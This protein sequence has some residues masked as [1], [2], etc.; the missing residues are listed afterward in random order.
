MKTHSIVAILGLSLV[1]SIAVA[2][3]IPDLSEIHASKCFRECSKEAKGDCKIN[4]DSSSSSSSGGGMTSEDDCFDGIENCFH[5]AADCS[6]YCLTCKEPGS[7]SLSQ[8]EC[9]NACV[10]MA[11]KCTDQIQPCLDQEKE[12]L[13]GDL[14]DVGDK[15]ADDCV[16][17][18][19]DCV[20]DCIADIEN[21]LRGKKD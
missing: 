11:E 13:K 1:G 15:L 9:N 7:C 21:T 12:Q 8:D 17:P 14:N 10:H 4:I 6:D 5:A 3:H 18:L 16:G 19:M 20:S 2:C